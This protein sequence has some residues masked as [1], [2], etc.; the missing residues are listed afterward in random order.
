M[1]AHKKLQRGVDP[2][3]L[4]GFEKGIHSKIS[5][6]MPLDPYLDD[7]QAVFNQDEPEEWKNQD[8]KFKLSRP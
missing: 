7:L 4:K 5:R 8:L 1:A 6:Q 3:Y 2:D